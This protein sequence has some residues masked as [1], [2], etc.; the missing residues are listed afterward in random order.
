MRPP[1]PGE[2]LPP[3]LQEMLQLSDA[4]RKQLAELQKE[5]E[6]KLGKILTEEQK[7]RLKALREG[8]PGGFGGPPGGRP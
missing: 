6:G 3:F 2:I 5:V 1:Q 8:G 7:A 4:Q